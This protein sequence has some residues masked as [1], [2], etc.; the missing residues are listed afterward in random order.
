M[1][2]VK[3]FNSTTKYYLRPSQLLM[4]PRSEMS[5]LL[6]DF[7]LAFLTELEQLQVK[8]LVFMKKKKRK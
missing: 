3:P 2:S 6:L 1:S 8:N 4:M 5:L 7:Y